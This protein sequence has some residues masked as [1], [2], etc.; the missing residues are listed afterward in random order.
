MAVNLS[1]IDHAIFKNYRLISWAFHAS[2]RKEEERNI[3]KW[4]YPI[5]KF[6]SGETDEETGEKLYRRHSNGFCHAQI[7]DNDNK[8]NVFFSLSVGN[9]KNQD[10]NILANEK[11]KLLFRSDKVKSNH[12]DKLHYVVFIHFKNMKEATIYKVNWQSIKSEMKEKAA[13][14]DNDYIL[15]N[16]DDF[17]TYRENEIP[18][19]YKPINK[20]KAIISLHVWNNEKTVIFRSLINKET[21]YSSLKDLWEFLN[22]KSGW[23]CK[24]YDSF[25]TKKNQKK[26]IFSKDGSFQLTW[27]QNKDGIDV[28]VVSNNLLH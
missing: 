3:N 11:N 9:K 1:K 15:L 27:T 2:H 17:E 18:D 16:A 23:K 5:I 12:W 26:P 4:K 19:D 6:M 20:T 22:K 14:A 10:K 21:K 24:N 25:K 8:Y 28:L 7:I 13:N